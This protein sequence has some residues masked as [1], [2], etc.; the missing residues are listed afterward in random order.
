MKGSEAMKTTH[1][2]AVFLLVLAPACSSGPGG[3]PVGEAGQAAAPSEVVGYLGDEPITRAEVEAMA[4]SDVAKLRQQEFDLLSRA[5][6]Q[7]I[8]KRLLEA[9]AEANGVSLEEFMEAK[10]SSRLLPPTDAEI[11]EFYT[12]NQ[13][14]MG[15]R[16]KEQMS[17]QI[18]QYLSQQERSRLTQ[19][20]V[21]ELRT[22]KGVRVL[23]EPPR[24][25]V[26]IPEGEPSLGPEDA[27]VV[28]VEFSDFQCPYC[29]RAH[30]VIEQVLEQYA[31][32]IRFVY[33]DY[34][35]PNHPRALPAAAAARCAGE[36]G[37]Y[38]EYH[39][40]LMTVNGSLD[41]ADL[42]KR[43][44]DLNLDADAFSECLDSN[45]YDEAIRA[46]LTDGQAVGVTG[47]PA[48]FIN[49]RMLSGAQ[50]LEAFQKVLDDELARAA[51]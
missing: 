33:R 27:P 48:F 19:E 43:A 8:A 26:V 35:L 7:L 28:V 36:Q 23:L 46:G 12:K 2:M 38:W 15:G 30:A 11:D 37:R 32:Q 49:G 31:D 10:V 6:D 5:L 9:E 20:L 44:G 25:D 22:E 47:T 42:E 16:N 41:D 40:N 45:R 50:S 51:D 29:K 34:P 3:S 17:L 24:A 39:G 13:G 4:A 1:V 21:N 14:R 18:G